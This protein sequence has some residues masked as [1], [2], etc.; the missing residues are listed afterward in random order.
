[1]KGLGL[2]LEAFLRGQEFGGGRLGWLRPRICHSHESIKFGSLRRRLVCSQG[3]EVGYSGGVGLLSCVVICAVNSSL[4][5][6]PGGKDV[7]HD[8]GNIIVAGSVNVDPRMIL[9]PII[10]LPQCERRDEE[11]QASETFH[12]SQGH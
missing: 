7:A 10:I 4:A 8:I 1:M 5:P 2:A 3:F 9:R 12:V 6:R 11:D